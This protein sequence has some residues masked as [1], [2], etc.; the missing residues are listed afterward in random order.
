MSR[1]RS[2]FARTLADRQPDPAGR[3][4]LYVPY[5]QLTE[6]M[7]PLAEEDPH[8]V[9]IVLVEAPAK[10]ARRPYHR[11][12]LAL[13]L[14]NQRHFALEQAARGVAVRYEIAEGTF[15]DALLPLARELGPLR[16]MEPAERELRVDLATAVEA[17][18]LQVLPHDGWLT[19]REE[20]L[21]GAGASPPWRMDAFYRHVRR[22]TGILMEGGKPVGG[23]YSFDAENRR[24]W[25]GEPSAP[26]PPTFSADA[27]THEVASLIERRYRE[28]PG[29]LDLEHLPASAADADALWHWAMQECLPVFGPYEDAMSTQSRGLFHT[30]IAALLNLHRLTPR[31]VVTET[32]ALDLPLASQEGFIRQLLGWREFVRHVHRETDGF[33]RLGGSAGG[34]RTTADLA[35]GPATPSALDANWPLP[36]AFWGTASGFACL[37]TVVRDVWDDAYGHHITRLMVLANIATLLGISP[38][39]LTDWF[40]VAYAD[41]YDWVVEPNVL[42]MGTYAAGDVMTTKPYV[43][44]AAYINRMS[45]YCLDCGFDPKATCPLTD[46]YWQFLARN[47]DRLTGNPRVALPL[48]SLTRRPPTRRARDARV[49][50]AVRARLGGGEPVTPADLPPVSRRD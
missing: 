31:R 20:F 41:A 33:R 26:T 23:K 11:Q 12:K 1:P 36:P 15:A 2:T 17:G 28:H 24:P 48:R 39:E 29:R 6:T 46:L 9:G 25:R 3:R 45:D 37:D 43:S 32:L 8:D 4:W 16:V 18:A 27:V 49:L 5:D 47:R 44:G 14:A 42:G 22:A 10:A 30:R 40:W 34:P 19:T 35:A 7:G 13:L 50:D 21:A 38:R